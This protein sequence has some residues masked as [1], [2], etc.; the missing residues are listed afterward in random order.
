[1]NNN[2][3]RFAFSALSPLASDLKFPIPQALLHLDKKADIP[4]FRWV[5]HAC[6]FSF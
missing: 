2:H 6:H 5:F 4:F 1:M 3:P